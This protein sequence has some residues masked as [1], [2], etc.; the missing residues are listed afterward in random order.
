MKQNF[1]FILLFLWPGVYHTAR[2]QWIQ[3]LTLPSTETFQFISPVS[4]KIVW[5]ITSSQKI[6]L[7]VDS[8]ATW[9]KYT[10]TGFASNNFFQQLLALTSKVAFLTANT[11]FTGKGPGIVYK[12][13]D[14]GHSWHQVF[15]HSGNC[16]FHLGMTNNKNGLLMINYNILGSNAHQSLFATHD[17]GNTWDSTSVTDPSSFYAISSFFL[18]GNQVWLDANDTLF[19]SADFA[20]TWTAEALPPAL[21]FDYIYFASNDYGIANSGPL[22]DLYLK[23]PPSNDWIHVGDPTGKG[24]ALIWLLVNGS[25]GAFATPLDDQKNYFSSDS[26]ETFNPVAVDPTD[27]FF[28]LQKAQHGESLWGFTLFSKKVYANFTTQQLKAPKSTQEDLNVTFSDNILKIHSSVGMTENFTIHVYDL[29]GKTVSSLKLQGEG[30]KN[31]SFLPD[32]V[33]VCTVESSDQRKGFPFIV[34]Q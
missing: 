11:G 30:E 16:D 26:C 24:G 1:L 10:A 6:Y 23:K 7:T 14:G 3:M 15:S 2:A 9:K 20:H 12:T 21:D 5:A 28:D 4:D 33:Y 34:T 32:G 29:N 22:I 17:G 8:G 25:T 31:F 19:Y 13:T 27:A 18:K